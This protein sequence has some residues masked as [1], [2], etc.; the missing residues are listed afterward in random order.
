VVSN[1]IGIFKK[2]WADSFGPRMEDILQNGLFA[3]IEQRRPVSILGL[4]KLLTDGA[5]RH[6]TLGEVHNP[7]VRGS[8]QNT[9]D[10]WQN[11][12]REEAI[13]PVLNKIRAFT[14]DPLLRAVI[15]QARSS[16]DFRDAM[17]SR[18]IILCDLSKGS[19]GADNATLLGSL[20]VIQEKLAALSRGDIPEAERVPHLLYA[21]EAQNF[22]GDFESI[23][24]E[25]RK[26]KLTVTVATQNVESLT[27]EAVAAVFTNCGTLISFRVSGAD[28]V[29]LREEFTMLSPG[30]YI[31]DL[32]DHQAYVRTLTCKDGVCEPADPQ[33]IA[34][35]PPFGRTRDTE[36]R[37]KIVRASNE[38]YTRP[39]DHVDAEIARFLMRTEPEG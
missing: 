15:G 10:R 4:P 39:R 34:T 32:P 25:T 12:F 33:V 3:L 7:A 14:T 2:L 36:W 8:F 28:A 9:F 18:R 24:S 17:D 6:S 22:I 35:Y 29:R 37:S 11:A 1:V 20:I 26:F 27:R 16:F 19:I 13:S 30:A 5:Y 23:L 31:Q 38:R 21:E